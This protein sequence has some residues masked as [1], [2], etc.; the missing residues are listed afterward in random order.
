MS[1]CGPPGAPGG[2]GEAGRG[3][4]V[5]VNPPTP[6]ASAPRAPV[7]LTARRLLADPAGDHGETPSPELPRDAR[8]GADRVRCLDAYEYPLVRGRPG[9]QDPAAV[10]RGDDLVQANGVEEDALPD[11]DV[12]ARPQHGH[13]VSG[14]DEGRVEARAL[15]AS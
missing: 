14:S 12:A 3:S 11:G 2:A 10:R 5:T 9:Q 6:S 4:V 7:S 8:E 13:G 1:R 15:A